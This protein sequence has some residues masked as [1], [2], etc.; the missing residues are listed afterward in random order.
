MCSFY[1]IS[2]VSEA[3]SLDAPATAFCFVLIDCGTLPSPFGGGPD[4][5]AVS[6][7]D[8]QPQA[9]R[10]AAWPSALGSLLTIQIGFAGRRLPDA[11]ARATSS[12]L[13]TPASAATMASSSWAAG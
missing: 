7:L 3:V 13:A 8:I 2:Q 11:S 9:S 1:H 12:Q 10:S 4:Y 5:S 6:C